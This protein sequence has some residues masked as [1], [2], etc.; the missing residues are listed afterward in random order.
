TRY[1]EKGHQLSVRPRRG[2]G[3]RSDEISPL[4]VS[5]TSLIPARARRIDRRSLFPPRMCN[6]ILRGERTE[7]HYNFP[8]LGSDTIVQL[9]L[10]VRRCP[11][12][13]IA[14]REGQRCPP[15]PS[16]LPSSLSLA[17]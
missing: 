15:I 10:E 16:S 13:L 3:R 14:L 2:D 9:E 12:G 6:L 8:S 5:S 7:H 1:G 4:R 17:P 11:P